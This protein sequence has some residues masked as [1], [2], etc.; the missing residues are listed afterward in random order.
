MKIAVCDDEKTEIVRLTGILKNIAKDVSVTGFEEGSALLQAASGEPFDLVFLDIRLPGRENGIGIA[1]ELMQISPGTKIAFVSGSDDHAIE[2]F[3]INALHYILKPYT[4]GDI[5][6]V[7]RRFRQ[8]PELGNMITIRIG[9]DIH[10][11]PQNEIIKVESDR[12]HTM[13]TMTDKTVHSVRK[14]FSDITSLLDEDFLMIK[15]GVAVNMRHIDR[16]NSI[17]I[18]LSDDTKYLLRRDKR[19]EIRETY[20]RFT[21]KRSLKKNKKI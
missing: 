3:G 1:R 7:L 8:K 4:S 2:A 11:L 14:N 10:T 5:E 21:D 15:R 12:H 20:T 19:R 9:R 18:H 13:I 17:E 6:E 16:F